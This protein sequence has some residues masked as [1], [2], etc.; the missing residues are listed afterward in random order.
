VISE[1]IDR[2]LAG[3]AL[4]AGDTEAA[5]G[6]VMRGEADPAQIAG[7]LVALRAKGETVDELVG[8]AR[9]MRAHVVA[10]RPA[11]DDLVD[12]AGTGGDG[13]GT[14]NIST[15]AALV[16][17]ACGC[18]VAKHG[19]RAASSRSGSADVLEALG[20][21]IALTPEQAAAM[22]EQHGF[23]YLHAPDH[24]PAMRH[25]GPVRRS[26]GVRTV[27]NLLGPLTNPAGARRQLIGVYARQWVEPMAQALAALGCEHGMV[28]HG[29]PGIDELSPCGATTVATVR[30]GRVTIGELD[31]RDLGIDL[32]ALSDL[33]GGDPQRNAEIALAVLG[34]VAGPAADATALNAAAA[35]VVAGRA[36]DLGEG[37]EQAR[38]ALRSGA[39]MARLSALR[40]AGKDLQ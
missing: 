13:S 28:V 18:A 31:A 19:N 2:L 22:I 17:A 11:R 23:G 29:E 12:T 15:T 36:A 33:A 25:A 14:F 21:P 7:L 1:T 4:S 6:L 5:V 26:L 39:A 27:F 30:G 38:E 10:V 20:V 35:I 32:C 9:A 16:A 37:L 3:D 34:G 40:A 24:H 8:A